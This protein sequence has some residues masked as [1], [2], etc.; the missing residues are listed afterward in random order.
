MMT[1][2]IATHA[3]QGQGR[4][5][6]DVVEHSHELVNE[7]FCRKIFRQLLQSL[8]TQY[9]MQMPHRAITPD[10][11]V[12]QE[13][14]EPLLLPSQL[15]TDGQGQA[16]DL[17]ALASVV[18]YAITREW[19]PARPLVPRRLDGFSDSLV[20]AIDKCLA[21]DPGER[22]Q[23]IDELRNLLG[24]VSLGPAVPATPPQFTPQ[25]NTPQF[26]APAA[27]PEFAEIAGSSRHRAPLGR[28][29]RWVLI[30][31]AACVLLAALIGLLALLRG[32]DSG[33]VVALSLPPAE[34]AARGLAPNETMVVAPKPAQ[35][36]PAM[37]ASGLPTAPPAPAAAPALPPAVPLAVQPAPAQAP[38]AAQP[39]PQAAPAPG[40][41]TTYKLAIRPWGTVYVDGQAYGVSPPLKRLALP[42]GPHTVRIVNPNYRDR[43]LRI[44]AGR[45]ATG[46]IVHNFSNRSR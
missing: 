25:H 35:P 28:L 17:H 12:F 26:A 34:R 14:G 13:N 38:A 10:T 30:G 23:T 7:A 40:P 41:F 36:A 4:T 1:S 9:S 20:G 24:I 18:H 3:Q 31:G 2:T 15:P 27:A 44:Y 32:T 29:Q 5:V 8:E 33:D 43:V 22:P 46:K 37:P 19:P 45:S 6:R 42:A 11:V 39:V 16:D 21:G